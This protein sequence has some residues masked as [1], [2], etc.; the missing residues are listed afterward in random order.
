MYCQNNK[1]LISL[2]SKDR[3]SPR[4]AFIRQSEAG[5]ALIIFIVAIA[6]ALSILTA[7]IFTSIGQGKNTFRG[8][9]GRRLYYAAETGI[10]YALLRLIR[11]PACSGADNIIIDSINVAIT[12]TDAGANCLVTSKAQNQNIIKTIQVEASYD[13][14]WVFNYSNWT[15]VP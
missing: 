12:Y 1:R 13:P 3:G 4:I 14:S 9:V 8:L 10:E 2:A 11:N 7:A 5:Q 15:E 6:V